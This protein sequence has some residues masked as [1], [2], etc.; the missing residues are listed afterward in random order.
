MNDSVERDGWKEWSR[1]IINLLERLDTQLNGLR[2]E[3]N[4]ANLDI[5]KLSYLNNSLAELENK[6]H[7]L[8]SE[9]ASRD[10]DFREAIDSLEKDDV[11][12]LKRVEDAINALTIKV[13][14]LQV[15]MTRAKTIAG[16]ISAILLALVGM[17]SFSLKDLFK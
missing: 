3:V 16:I 13:E 5:A 2:N 9:L 10:D 6:I 1:H 12:N 8:R 7:Q 11:A 4:K 14:T 15:F 17:L